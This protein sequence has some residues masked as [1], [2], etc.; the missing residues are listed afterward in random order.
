MKRLLLFLFLL[1][2]PSLSLS[3]PA[4]PSISVSMQGL[5]LS[6]SWNPVAGADGYRLS[7]AALPYT[8]PESIGTIDVG[9]TTSFFYS[10]WEGAAFL[11]A[12]QAYDSQESSDYSNTATVITPSAIAQGAPQLFYN[13]DDS[14][15]TI[16]WQPVLQ[17]NGLSAELFV[18]RVF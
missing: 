11:V 2:L 5:D 16:S 14:I 7:Y 10:L 13:L 15:V 8:G 3:T 17:R 12:V 4:P 6:M 18:F 9:N 1:S